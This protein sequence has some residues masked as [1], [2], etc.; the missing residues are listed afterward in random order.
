MYKISSEKLSTK[1][2]SVLVGCPHLDWFSVNIHFV[3]VCSPY[4]YALLLKMLSFFA[5]EFIH[6]HISKSSFCVSFAYSV[7]QL[8]IENIVA[9]NGS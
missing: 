4:G 3:I 8:S 7:S 1:L 2:R 5:Y 9:E 6:F